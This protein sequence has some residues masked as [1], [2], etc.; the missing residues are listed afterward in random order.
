MNEERNVV[1]SVRCDFCGKTYA[2][3]VT[4][5]SFEEF[6][7]PNRRHIQDI[8]PYLGADERELLISH[9][10]GF[11]WEKIFS[12]SEHEEL[13]EKDFTNDNDCVDFNQSTRPKQKES[14][15]MRERFEKAFDILFEESFDGEFSKERELFSMM[16]D[17]NFAESSNLGYSI[18]RALKVIC[19]D[20]DFY[21]EVYIPTYGECKEIAPKI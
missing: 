19:S 12:F 9:T 3:Y 20:V 15:D 5:E 6:T 18:T 17:V 14:K 16:A 2:V 8:F 11:C 13:N 4:E 21:N 7:S 1:L 10:C